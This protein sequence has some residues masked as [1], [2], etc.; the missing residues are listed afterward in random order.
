[1][2]NKKAKYDGRGS[3]SRA[4]LHL[5]GKSVSMFGE[6]PRI[7][8][9]AAWMNVSKVT[10]TKYL[11]KMVES[12]EIIMTKKQYKNTFV[13]EVALDCDIE[14]EFREGYFVNDYQQ[15]AQKVMGIILHA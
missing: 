8:D 14:E 11:K 12:R 10:A 2:K 7:S 1:M 3:H 6:Y 4:I 5:I 9:I 15:Y 13:Y